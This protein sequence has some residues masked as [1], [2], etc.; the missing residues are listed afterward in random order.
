M[1]TWPL[2]LFFTGLLLS[3]LFSG[4][5]TGFYR[6]TR[7]R[8][9][10]D[11]KAGDRLSRLLLWW[12]NNPSVFVANILIGNNLANYLVSLSLVMFVKVW[13]A[14]SAQWVEFVAPILLTPI[15]F[16]Y[17]ESLPKNLFL[18][19]PNR[20]IRWVAPVLAVFNFI[21][22]PALIVLWGLGR[23]LEFFLGKSP[24]RIR[25]RLA[26]KELINVLKEG[27]N[28]GLLEPVQLQLAQ[29]FFDLVDKSLDPLHIPLARIISVQEGSPVGKALTL[30][31]R[32]RLTH[33][34]V[35]DKNGQLVGHVA[36]GSLVLLS[37]DAKIEQYEPF[38]QIH[39]KESVGRALIEMRNRDAELALMID[40]AGHA[41]GM[42][43]VHRL[44]EQLFTG[45]LV[46]WK[47]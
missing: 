18:Q 33:I 31:S 24:E 4:S 8:W 32:N 27:H 10:L 46:G 34:P 39:Q 14:N 43:A 42:L 19:A 35:T 12:A 41:K 45:S 29:N 7:V 22:T 26:R 47:R 3:S 30:A 5:E 44:Y 2:I 36:V 15:L 21:F 40:D 13:F 9:V 1:I 16:V 17:G 23:M 38:I 6:A 28:I 20:L 11:G 25:S 37:E